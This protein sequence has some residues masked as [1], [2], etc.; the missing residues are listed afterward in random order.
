ML[1][2]TTFTN[3]GCNENNKL[4][5]ETPT[6]IEIY[7]NKNKRYIKEEISA[8]LNNIMIRKDRSYLN[9]Y[10]TFTL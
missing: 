4:D 1:I 3:F 6:K 7:D 8:H 2:D 5:E 10:L 9:S